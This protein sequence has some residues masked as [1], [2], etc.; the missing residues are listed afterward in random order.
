[1]LKSTLTS[2]H[3]VKHLYVGFEAR[4]LG[5][6]TEKALDYAGTGCYSSA[7]SGT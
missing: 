3:P 5:H 4:T 2:F 7:T 1:M 6:A